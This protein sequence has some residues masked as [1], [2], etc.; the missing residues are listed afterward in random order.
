MMQEERKNMLNTKQQEAV[1][2]KNGQMLVVS[3]PGSGKT[4]VIVARVHQLIES[5]VN[6]AIF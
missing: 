5:G 6:Q 2:F 1:N 4:T 3:C